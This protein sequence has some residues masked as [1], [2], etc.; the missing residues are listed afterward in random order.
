MRLKHYL[1]SASILSGLCIATSGY[2]ADAAADG[3]DAGVL[4][5]LIVTGTRRA[6]NLQDVPINIS[7]VSAETL[8]TQRLDDIKDLVAFTPGVTMIDTGPRGTGNFIVRG[9]SAN[10][11][12]VTGGNTSGGAVKISLMWSGSQ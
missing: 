4:E 6:V 7:A 8:E 3:A 11:T 9:L 10:N 5:E 1:F 2:A 12:G